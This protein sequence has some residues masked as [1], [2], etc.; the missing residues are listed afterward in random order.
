MQC[1]HL[2]SAVTGRQNCPGYDI[3][4]FTL[5]PIN[6][7]SFPAST[8]FLY[9]QHTSVQCVACTGTTKHDDVRLM[10]SLNELDE[11]AIFISICKYIYLTRWWQHQRIFTEFHRTFPSPVQGYFGL[12]LW[13]ACINHWSTRYIS[14]FFV[15]KVSKRKLQVQSILR[16]AYYWNKDNWKHYIKECNDLMKGIWQ[17]LKQFIYLIPVWFCGS[18]R[19]EQILVTFFPWQFNLF[20]WDWLYFYL[21]GIHSFLKFCL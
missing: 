12:A 18:G 13:F 9:R 5:M 11:A 10:F 3:S 17:H 2:A 4:S 8:I 7:L 21:L 15:L 19:K 6:E 14:F 1:Q 16:T 20:I